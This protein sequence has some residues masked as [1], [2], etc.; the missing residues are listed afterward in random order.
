MTLNKRPRKI[1]D[2]VAQNPPAPPTHSRILAPFREENFSYRWLIMGY[3]VRR[4]NLVFASSPP[5]PGTIRRVVAHRDVVYVAFEDP[6]VRVWVLKRGRKV[7]ELAVA[8]EG[9][10]KATEWRDLVVFG[11]WVVGVLDWGMAVWRRETREVYTTIEVDN[12]GEITAAVHPS[13]YLNKMVIARMGGVLEIWNVKT[14]KKI[15]TILSPVASTGKEL[16]EIASLVQTPAISVLAIGF[17]TGEVHLHIQA[18]RPLF[19]LGGSAG[20]IIAATSHVA[21]DS[22]GNMLAVGHNDGDIT[23]WNLKK[24]RIAATMRNAHDGP[25]GG[26][27]VEWIFDSPHTTLPRVLRSRSGHSKPITSLTFLNPS[28]SHFLLSSSL[29]SSFRA[30]S[31]RNDAQSFVPSEKAGGRRS[32]EPPQSGEKGTWANREFSSSNPVTCIATVAG[33]DGAGNA[34]NAARDLAGIIT[35]HRDSKSGSLWS[36]ENKS[37]RGR[38]AQTTD[39]GLVRSVGSSNGGIAMY[40]IQSGIK[41]RQFPEPHMKA[42]TGIVIDSLNRVVITGKVKFWDFNTGII[43]HEI[44]WSTSGAI[45]KA[46]IS[47]FCFSNDGRWVVGA[48]ADRVIRVWDLPTGHMIDGTRTKS[49]VTAMAFS[50]T[51][52]F[53]A[54][55]HVDSD[56]V[57]MTAP[58]AS[59]EGGVGVIEAALNPQGDGEDDCTGTYT[60][61][62]QLTSNMLTMSLVPRA[63]WQTL[64]NLDV[65]KQGNK[66]KEAPKTPE[67]APFFLPPLGAK[68]DSFAPAAKEITNDTNSIQPTDSQSLEAERSRVL[69]MSRDSGESTFTKLLREAADCN[70]GDYTVILAHLKA[71]SPSTADLEIRSL[72]VDEL[73]PFVR[74]IT[75]R[76]RSRRDYELVQTWG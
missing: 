21:T 55:A 28:T 76:L 15:Y 69:R 9:R 1:A 3:Y 49:D 50:G 64:L 43:I 59:G 56:I 40:N 52:E 51:G 13:T 11:D 42:V 75:Q 32:R 58:F 39:G 41:R 30:H 6:L 53:L 67:K 70:N 36:F 19:T 71:L 12:R 18:D 31:M 62:D 44:D 57:D 5:T 14:G 29:D 16:L 4:L 33:E 72:Q 73:V 17:S 23:L 27:V 24:R 8:G 10:K 46:K 60:T 25:L 61:V 38:W 22:G 26:G 54:T 47:D 68:S 37:F 34:E 20:D 48:S 7:A 74:A 45:T 63:R 2:S 65:I 66:P 35:G